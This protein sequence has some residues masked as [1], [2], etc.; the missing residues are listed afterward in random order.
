MHRRRFNSGAVSGARVS[1][2]GFAPSNS[3]VETVRAR[4]RA[5]IRNRAIPGEA[6]VRRVAPGDLSGTGPE[7][8]LPVRLDER[9]R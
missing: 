2:T 6:R 1:R 5:T 7:T 3:S 4:A 8:I 9:G